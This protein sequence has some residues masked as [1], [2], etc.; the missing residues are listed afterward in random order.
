MHY[1]VY[2][3][4]WDGLGIMRHYAALCQSSV[5]WEYPCCL[6]YIYVYMRMFFLLEKLHDEQVPPRERILRWQ[7]SQTQKSMISCRR[8]HLFLQS[9][10]LQCS[11]HMFL[12]MLCYT[13]PYY[14]I[15]YYKL[16][17]YSILY[18]SIL[19]YCTLQYTIPYP[20]IL[21]YTVIYYTIL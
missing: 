8:E 9:G 2:C 17:Y 10:V 4:L 7:V 11:A 13:I 15:V 12:F 1:T 19:Q 3:I 14:S 16:L 5:I 18:Y 20:T 6:L 21:Y